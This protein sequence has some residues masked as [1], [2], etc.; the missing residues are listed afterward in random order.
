MKNKKGAIELSINTIVILFLALAMLGV[1]MFIINKMRE[2]VDV[3][4]ISDLGSDLKEQDRQR[5]EDADDKINFLSHLIKVK[6][7]EE[8]GVAYSVRN[9]LDQPKNFALEIKCLQGLGATDEELES[10]TSSIKINEETLSIDKG[11]TK[12]LPMLIQPQSTITPTVYTCVI[13]VKDGDAVYTQDELNIE[14]Y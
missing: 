4:D 7:G 5:L 1:G 11:K 9:V 6:A 13:T 2:G 10:L 14:V 12:V 8:K 3:L